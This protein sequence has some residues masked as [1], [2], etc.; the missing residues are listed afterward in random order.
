MNAGDIQP[1][2]NGNSGGI[3]PAQR[4]FSLSALLYTSFPENPNAMASL[5]ASHWHNEALLCRHCYERAFPNQAVR[6]LY[7]HNN[8]TG[9]GDLHR[10]ISQHAQFAT[11]LPSVPSF[12]SSTIDLPDQVL[13]YTWVTSSLH[14][15]RNTSF[16][17]RKHAK[18]ETQ[19]Q[20]PGD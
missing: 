13:Q 20:Q 10:E 4:S 8:T 11:H 5:E 6:P 12:P 18:H 17:P 1:Q 2:C 16:I 9:S 19:G 15:H 14:F 7:V 3:L